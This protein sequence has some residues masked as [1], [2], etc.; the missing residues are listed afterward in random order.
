MRKT[1]FSEKYVINKCLVSKT[2]LFLGLI[3]VCSL[4]M[5][6]QVP[7]NDLTKSYTFSNANLQNVAN[8]GTYDL[9]TSGS[10]FQST[11]DPGGA[12]NNALDVND[13]EFNGGQHPTG[14]G[15]F[16]YSF[17]IR[18]SATISSFVVS[19]YTSTSGFDAGFQMFMNNGAFFFRG[20]FKYG[21]ITTADVDIST[22]A[23]NDGNWHHI[24]VVG[25]LINTFQS[26]G[27]GGGDLFNKYNY[28]LY[29]DNA[30]VDTVDTSNI[31][32]NLGSGQQV[33]LFSNSPDL[34]I[35][36]SLYSDD[37]DN[38]REYTRILSV[39]E[40]DDLFNEFASSIC[41]VN[42]P[43]ANFKAALL[44]N[45]AINMN[46]DSEIQCDEASQY[47]G[48]L[49]L[50]N[51][52]ISNLQGIEAFTSATSID[53]GVNSVVSADFSFANQFTEI[54][55]T[56]NSTLS[57]IDLSGCSQ[58]EILNVNQSALTTLDTSNTPLL[59]EVF[60]ILSQISTI[61]VSG[62]PLLESIYLEDNNLQDIDLTSNSN[63]INVGLRFNNLT[64]V[65]VANGNNAKITN[66]DTRNNSNLSCIQI[67]TGFSVPTDNTWR[68][69]STASYSDNCANLSVNDF[70]VEGF[71][72]YPNPASELLT[73]ETNVSI[74]ALKIYSVTGKLL[75]TVKNTNTINVSG[76]DSG[77]YFVSVVNKTGS[78]STLRFIK[79]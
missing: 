73:I 27:F 3:I 32:E 33:S 24:V 55:A 14:T 39:S 63:L 61:D 45:T 25:E 23:I 2:K 36:N 18:T 15:D 37:L 28:K 17:W 79:Q 65:N 11:D 58:L 43:D 13:N 34:I 68:K 60:A 1:T 9:T 31:M 51:D 67:D 12:P 29:L 53:L 10:A 22:S 7:T 46:N 56:T 35:G 64:F 49:N 52:G 76:L 72:I 78:V 21:N 70:E 30:F 38:F 40:I 44:A 54:N 69:P 6:A 71:K 50:F 19:Q 66:F 48:A 59:R 41:N 62:S 8:A 42:I 5:Q 47:T 16:S 57:N 74:D 20:N 4:S 26:D 77:I 75:N